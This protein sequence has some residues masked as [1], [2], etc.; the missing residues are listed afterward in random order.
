MKAQIKAA[1]KNKKPIGPK[2]SLLFTGPTFPRYAE[3]TIEER[4][5]IGSSNT[6]AQLIK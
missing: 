6:K 5:N 1:R 4:R 3:L 2:E